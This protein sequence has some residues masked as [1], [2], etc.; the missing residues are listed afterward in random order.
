MSD[1]DLAGKLGFKDFVAFIL[2]GFTVLL[3]LALAGESVRPG[4]LTRLPKDTPSQI[5]LA[6]AAVAVSWVLG[7]ASAEALRGFERSAVQ[8][9]AAEKELLGSAQKSFD[10][11]CTAYFGTTLSLE[12]KGIYKSFYMSRALVREVLPAA[13]AKMERAGALRQASKNVA[14]PAF[15]LGIGVAIW[16]GSVTQSASRYA[17]LS[18]VV[19]GTL[20]ACYALIIGAAKA[21]LREMR[22]A[23]WSIAALPAIEKLKISKTA[24]K[25]G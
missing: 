12:G 15:I 16:V 22:E 20:L 21:R 19:A 11:A 17:L 3:A 5:W 6:V 4:M 25:A 9:L 14:V 7:V 2:P 24:E 8:R 10:D 23:F 1:F 18:I 13:K